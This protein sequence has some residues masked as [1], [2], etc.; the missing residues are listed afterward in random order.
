MFVAVGKFKTARLALL[1]LLLCLGAPRAEAGFFEDLFGLNEPAPQ[2]AAPEP[3]RRISPYRHVA[4]PGLS[5]ERTVKRSPR[6]VVVARVRPSVVVVE[7][8]T[9]ARLVHPALCY[10]TG[11]QEN[12]SDHSDALLHD[13]T[14]RSGDTLVTDEG[15]RIFNGGGSCPHK[16]ADFRSLAEARGLS[17]QKRNTLIAIEQVMHRRRGVDSSDAVVATDKAPTRR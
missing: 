14:L 12:K 13:E 1:A 3:R 6:K 15:V 10:P 16:P 7:S 5:F 11:E 2:R 8:A 9:G 17:G 4:R